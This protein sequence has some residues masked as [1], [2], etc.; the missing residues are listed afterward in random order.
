MKKATI[1][2]I[3]TAWPYRGGIAAFNERLAQEFSTKGCT[4]VI[5]NFKLQ[6]PGF[7][8]P[9]K[10]Q[11]VNSPAPPGL[12]IRRTVNSVNPLNWI[13]T[14]NRIRKQQP[15]LVLVRFWL[16]FMGPCFGTIARRIKR[17]RNIP[18]IAVIDNIIPHEKRIG[19]R[20]FTRYFVKP[21]DAFVTMSRQVLEDTRRFDR[22]KPRTLSPHP[23]YD[24]FGEAITPG[25]AKQYL[26]LDPKT[27]Y[28]MFFGFI[29]EYKG[30]DL[31]LKAFA[32]EPVKQL[33]VK[34]LV[35]GEFYADQKTYLDLVK[36]YRLEDR[37]VWRSEFI[38][39]D[40]VR[41]YF[42]ACD[43][44]VQPYKT[45]TQSGISQIA[46][47][48]EKPMIVTRVGG[49][50]EIVPDGKAGYVTEK[51]PGKIAGAIARFYREEKMDA[52]TSGAREEKKKYSWTRLVENILAMWRLS[53]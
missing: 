36:Q 28:V 34:L 39:D 49:L 45:A 32:E 5:E 10:S 44:V 19:D 8:F 23:L 48:F 22:K 37:V 24:H 20:L 38:P 35:A 15:D 9:G 3:G 47:H 52:F 30:L 13:R 7:L 33:P 2:I 50:P 29:R 16:P 51:D 25:E 14:G 12:T 31:L 40:Q 27:N 4:V 41:Y 53:V 26:R 6:Y 46:Y 1:I 42:S 18:V 43:L 11:Y 17:N 21:V